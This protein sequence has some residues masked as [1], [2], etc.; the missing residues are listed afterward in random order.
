[1]NR[2]IG[3]YLY[4]YVYRYKSIRVYVTRYIGIYNVHI[5]CVFSILL[6]IGRGAL[7]GVS[8]YLYI[9]INLCGFM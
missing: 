8:M 4:A 9:G 6:D 5:L 7:F 3:I 1:V 2:H